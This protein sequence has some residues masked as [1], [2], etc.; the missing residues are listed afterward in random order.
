MHYLQ[1][2]LQVI[3][4][5]LQAENFDYVIDL[6]HN[7]R[8]MRVKKHWVKIVFFQWLNIL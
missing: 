3:I 7:L 6:H 5:A 1:D 4:P 2:D 8:T